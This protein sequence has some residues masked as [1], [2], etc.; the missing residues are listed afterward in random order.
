MREPTSKCGVHLIGAPI[1]LFAYKRPRHTLQTLTALS[2]NMMASRSPLIVFIDGPKTEAELTDIEAVRCV[3][4]RAAGFASVEVVERQANYGL[5]RSI[6]EGVSSVLRTHG[7]VVV[8]EDDIVTSPHFLCY[9]NDALT[10]YADEALV[11]SIHAYTYPVPAPLPDTFFLRGADCW[12]WATWERAWCHMQQD[13]R[14]LLEQITARGLR[15][16]FDANG[17]RSLVRMLQQQIEG[18]NDSWAVRWHASAF[19]AGMVTLYPGRSLVQNIGLDSS[20]THC[21]ETE[22]FA[23]CL[24]DYHV[25]VERLPA[26]ENRRAAEAFEHYFRQ[27]SGLFAQCRSLVGSSGFNAVVRRLSNWRWASND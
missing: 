1:V 15:R 24:D 17:S 16:E 19:L 8:V 10:I 14:A 7:R 20:G 5:A 12:G 3:V 26:V 11:A 18:R 21:R 6:I 23:V 25:H 22:R 4:R 27:N 9:M 13:G 2:R